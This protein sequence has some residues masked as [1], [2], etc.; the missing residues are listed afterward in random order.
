MVTLMVHTNPLTPEMSCFFLSCAQKMLEIYEG[1]NEVKAP[2]CR[3]WG[4]LLTKIMDLHLNYL[5]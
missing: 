3:V 2:I 5:A 4:P 1:K